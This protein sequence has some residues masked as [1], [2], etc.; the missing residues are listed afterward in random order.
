MDGSKATLRAAQNAASQASSSVA[1]ARG[2]VVVMN[3][4]GSDATLSQQVQQAL[5][6]E[7]GY[8]Q[9]VTSTLSNPTGQGAAQLATLATGDQSALVPLA[10]LAPGI[11]SSVSGT[12]NLANWAQG[13]A[14]T[15]AAA[16][17][18]QQA[19]SSGSSGG[20]SSSTGGT[21]V[22]TSGSTDCGNG[23]YAGPNTSCAFAQNV[24]DAWLAAPGTSNTL[25]VYS[26]VT[27]KTYTMNCAPAGSG[28]TCSGGNN[29]SVSW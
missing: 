17:A 15:A 10:S 4:P 19:N 5:A 12:D 3:V 7:N 23:I 6:A 29:A 1:A 8:V 9:D 28:I 27:H 21:S 13:A 11:D 25:Q 24:H 16:H 20:S 26:P 22:A 18:R 14:G 2:A